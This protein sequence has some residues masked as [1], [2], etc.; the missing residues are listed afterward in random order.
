[1]EAGSEEEQLAEMLRSGG[2]SVVLGQNGQ[3]VSGPS[4]EPVIVGPDGQELTIEPTGKLR[5]Y[6][7]RRAGAV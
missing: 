3:A 1:M 7:G 6:K 4:G 2:M 5:P